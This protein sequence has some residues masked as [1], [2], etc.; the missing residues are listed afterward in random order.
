MNSNQRDR[1][2]FTVQ[3]CTYRQGV[4]AVEIA[5][6]FDSWDALRPE[7]EEVLPFNSAETRRR[8]TS[9]LFRWVLDGGDVNSFAVRV[10]R[11]YEDSELV[12]H[13][14]RERYLNVYPVLGRL[15]A[16]S[17][18]DI[19]P[20]TE[21]DTKI[22]ERHL[23]EEQVGVLKQSVGK[24]RLTMRDLGFI[25]RIGRQYVVSETY[26]PK[27]AFL[28]SLHYHL[29]SEPRTIA[30]PVIIQ[31]PFWRHLGGRLEDEVRSALS[32][33]AASDA[34]SRYVTVDSLEQITTRFSLEELLQTHLRLDS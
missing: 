8:Y 31:H 24:L 6:K 17:L 22:L 28:L 29:A 4:T 19:P 12:N 1:Q 34:I 15:V 18:T 16:N 27:T 33:A 20:G 30:V 9:Q 10:W 26:L 32:Q 23:I 3:D 11:H 14:L 2:R 21:L 25:R 5:S 7:L 13:I